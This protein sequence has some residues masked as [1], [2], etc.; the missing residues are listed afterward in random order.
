MDTAGHRILARF[1]ERIEKWPPM[2]ALALAVASIPSLGVIDWISGPDIAFSV[3]YLLPLSIIGWLG[4]RNRYL[5]QLAPLLAAL[6]WLIADIAAGADYGSVL[7]PI[8]NTATRLI[9]FLVVV[10]LLQNLQSAVAEHRHLAE[11]DALTG[12]ANGRVFMSAIGAEISRAKRHGGAISVAYIDV[13]DF[14][15]INDSQGHAGGDDVLR[16]LGAALDQNTRE[17][18][19][20]G[21]LGGDEFGILLP[22]TD[23]AGSRAVIDHLRERVA[24]AMSDLGFPV[25]RSLGCVTFLEPPAGTGE[26]LHAADE[27]MYEVKRSSKNAALHKVI[28]PRAEVRA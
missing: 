21:R 11:I 1:S 7:I 13:D 23:E 16:R 25:T 26:I 8:W 5:P 22:M 3:F 14:K 27:L 9:I 10:M 28:P 2:T 6:T 18:D 20:V 19:I 24:G 4:T 17:I 12:V 15:T